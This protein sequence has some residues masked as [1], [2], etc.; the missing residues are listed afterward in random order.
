MSVKEF[1]QQI[2]L[3]QKK[4]DEMH[5]ENL[6]KP[7]PNKYNKKPILTKKEWQIAKVMFLILSF[8]II[9]IV[10]S[11][12]FDNNRL[13]WQLPII[14][15]TPVYVEKREGVTKVL[16]TTSEAQVVPEPTLTVTPSPTQTP[17]PKKAR[18][19][20]YSCGGLKT[21]SEIKMNCPSLLRGEPKTATGTTPI[22]NRT[23]ACDRANLGRVF[24]IEG[25]GQVVCE[26]VGSGVTGK[27]RFDLY[28]ATVEEARQFGVQELAYKLVE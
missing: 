3:S 10:I 20:A 6:K 9:V 17:P 14:L 15:R 22:A 5:E 23:V 7:K 13:V 2:K 28:L 27:A 19:S 21:Q 11:K 4:L 18:V 26:D 25:I 12:W 8:I 1:D 24:E 16:P